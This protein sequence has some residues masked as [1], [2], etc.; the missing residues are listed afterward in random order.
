MIKNV[1]LTQVS[2]FATDPNGKP[3]ISAKS[4]RPYTR[5]AIKAVEY[6]DQRLSGFGNEW[7]KDWKEGDEVTIDVTEKPNPNG[8]AYLNFDKANLESQLLESVNNLTR[9]VGAIEAWIKRHDANNPPTQ[10]T[11]KREDYPENEFPG[12]IPF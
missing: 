11:I 8:G 2:R 4:G 10:E 1:T 9:R 5:L 12:D 3:Y 7:N 6:G